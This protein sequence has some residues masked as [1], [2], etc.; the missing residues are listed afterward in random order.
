MKFYLVFL[1]NPNKP[2]HILRPTSPMLCLEYNPKDPHTLAGGCYNGQ[3]AIFDTR[4]GIQPVEV[5]PVEISHNDPVHKLIFPSSKT[6]MDLS[7][8]ISG[9]AA[10]D[11]SFMWCCMILGADTLKSQNFYRRVLCGQV[12]MCFPRLLMAE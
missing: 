11:I 3:I 2:E 7:A 4:K 8:L 12:L 10:R 5:T 6:G 1:E 9:L